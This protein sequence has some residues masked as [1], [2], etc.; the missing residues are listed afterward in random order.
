M[1]KEELE[2]G[3]SFFGKIV[4]IKCHRADKEIYIDFI[5][6]YL[7]APYANQTLLKELADLIDKDLEI[8]EKECNKVFGDL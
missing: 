7:Y 6:K 1:T 2:R 8:Q 4:A 5:H 3:Q